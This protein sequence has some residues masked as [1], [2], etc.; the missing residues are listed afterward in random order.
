MS[1][2]LSARLPSTW[3]PAR[4]ALSTM[5]LPEGVNFKALSNS[6][7]LVVEMR[8][9]HE[10]SSSDICQTLQISEQNLLVRLHRARWAL[11]C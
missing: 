10:R 2:P 7:R 9:L 5:R 1:A 3:P 8:L 6:P 4:A 11:G